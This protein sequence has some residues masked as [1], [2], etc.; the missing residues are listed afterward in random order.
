MSATP[1][2]IDSPPP[3]RMRTDSE[4][5]RDLQAKMQ[6][7]IAFQYKEQDQQDPFGTPTY[8]SNDRKSFS[9]L[10]QQNLQTLANRESSGDLIAEVTRAPHSSTRDSYHSQV[11]PQPDVGKGTIVFSGNFRNTSVDSSSS[12][13]TKEH[14]LQYQQQQLKKLQ[15]HL[16]PHIQQ[17]TPRVSTSKIPMAQS[18]TPQSQSIFP[19]PQ[20]IYAGYGSVED[21][22]TQPQQQQRHEFH[23]GNPDYHDP[24]EKKSSDEYEETDSEGHFRGT[25]RRRRQKDPSCCERICCLYRPIVNL[26]RQESLHRSYCYGAID[27]LL[28]GSGIVSAFWGLGVLSQRTALE[29]RLAILALAVAAC[30]A[31]SLCMALGHVWTT[32]VVASN[33]IEERSRER[34]LLEQNKA[35]SKGKLVDMLL[36][37]GMLKIDAMSLADTLEGYPDLFVSALMGDSLLAGSDEGMDDEQTDDGHPRGDPLHDYHIEAPGTSHHDNHGGL[38]N[39]PDT[40]ARDGPFG[41]FGSWKFPSYGRLQSGEFDA[42]NMQTQAILKESQKEGIFMMMGFSTF[43]VLPSLLWLLLPFLFPAPA[44][45]THAKTLSSTSSSSVSASS[46]MVALPSAIL[47]ILSVVVWCLGVW[48]SRFVDSN[49]MVFGMETIA[50]LL[51]CVFSAYSVAMILALCLN[52]EPSKGDKLLPDEFFF[53]NL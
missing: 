2:S 46:P 51:V 26:F 9:W 18:A 24:Y 44:T 43:A 52:L 21:S 32:Y 37:R 41:S 15:Q 7:L 22:T 53:H 23:Y 3:A 29:V 19:L 16:S 42:E 10:R 4:Q 35:E 33:H 45:S 30:V 6:H 25:S 36:T 40:A 49:W 28:T 27:G 47:L 20:Q 38:A 39:G 13:E 31:D 17:N 5:D 11:V 48:K 34:Q 12:P 8:N 14:Y 1:V 50:V